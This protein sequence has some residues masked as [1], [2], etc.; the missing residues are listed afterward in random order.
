MSLKQIAT[1][2]RNLAAPECDELLSHVER[3]RQE[4]ETARSAA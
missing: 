1:M 3:L 2:L 4:I